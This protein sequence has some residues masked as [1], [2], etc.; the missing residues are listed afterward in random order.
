MALRREE[1][2]LGGLYFEAEDA[3]D[4]FCKQLLDD[5]GARAGLRVAQG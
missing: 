1:P 3:R 4:L 2:E 5:V